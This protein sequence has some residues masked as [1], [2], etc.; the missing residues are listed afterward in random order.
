MRKIILG[1]AI[2]LD[3]F[4]EGPNGEFDWCFTDQDYGMSEFFT[5]ID[6]LFIGRK[7]YELM[8]AMGENASPGF[9]KMKE[10]IFSNSLKEVK[11]GAILVN[12]D[13]AEAAR[14]IRQEPGKDI[15]LFGGASLTAYFLE[16]GL[17][18]HLWL[19]VH[20]IL[21]GTGKRLFPESEHRTRL[22][23]IEA[24]TYNTGLV[25]LKYDLKK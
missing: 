9:P 15:W 25:S 10:F 24:K 23:L 14:K 6:S 16:H 18:D 8:Q 20:P 7:T 13:A 21:L 12:S 2:S 19:S 22:Q 5:H 1:L 4:I 17:I 3:G 11:P